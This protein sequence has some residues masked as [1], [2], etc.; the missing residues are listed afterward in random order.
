MMSPHEPFRDDQPALLRAVEYLLDGFWVARKGFLAEDVLAR[1]E[2]AQRP[3]DVQRIRQRDVDALDGPILEQGLVACVCVIDPMSSR[4]RL[5]ARGG[6]TPDRN[7]LCA[8]T[9]LRGLDD[10]AV[11]PRS[12]Q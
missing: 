6:T 7:D 3:L 10:V 8:V 11:H 12:R 5:G 1:L 2:R 9:L 4:E